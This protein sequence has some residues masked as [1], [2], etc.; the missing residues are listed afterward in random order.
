MAYFIPT[1]GPLRAL[2]AARKRQ[3]GVR[4][5]VPGIS[6]VPLVQRATAHLYSML[7]RRGFRIY[8]R[9]GRMLHSKMMV[10][11]GQYSVVGSAN[12]DPRS[13]R[14]NLEFVAV[15][16]SEAFARVL[17]RIARFEMAQSDRVT[18]SRVRR[19][20]WLDRVLNRMA[21]TLRWWL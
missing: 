13:M 15:I 4:V 9:R 17:T 21:W 1:G 6:D 18:L 3:V 12:L 20:S 7:L 5:V 11:D 2:L 16:R 19:I 10:I 8:E 14:I